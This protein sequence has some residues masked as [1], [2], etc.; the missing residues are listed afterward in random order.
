MFK[1]IKVYYLLDDII[2][3]IIQNSLFS[4]LLLLSDAIIPNSVTSIQ[5]NQFSNCSSLSK[6]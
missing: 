3:K 6:S 2:H 4:G 1:Y 5:E